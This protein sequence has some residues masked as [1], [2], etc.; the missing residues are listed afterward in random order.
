M[1]KREVQAHIATCMAE[2][3]DFQRA[4]VDHVCLRLY[5]EKCTRHLVADEVG[6]G[7]TIVAK[8][9]IAKAMERHLRST[10]AAEPFRVVYICSNQA[11]AGQNLIKLNL[12]KRK[13]CVDLN[14]SRLVFLAKKETSK[15]SFRII[16]LTPSTSF[17]LTK[18][19]GM[20]EERKLM[21]MLLSW[22]KV[23]HKGSRRNGLKLF[24]KGSVRDPAA[25]AAQLDVYE[26]E[27]HGRLRPD[28]YTRFKRSVMEEPVD[29]GTPRYRLVGEELGLQGVHSLQSIVLRYSERLRSNN[30]HKYAGP[31]RLIGLLRGLLT[32]ACLVYLKADLFILDEFQ[33]FKDLI[34]T[35]EE[36]ASDAALLAQQVFSIEKAK[37]LM[38][39][40][41]P[42]KP[43][44]TALEEQ[45][46]AESHH[47]EFEQVLGFLFKGDKEKVERYR[48][49]RKSFREL[50]KRAAE[51]DLDH[52]EAKDDLQDLLSEVMS[53]T[54]RL[55]VSDDHNTLIKS[56]DRSASTLLKN[57]I[58]DFIHTD[59]IAQVLKDVVKQPLM[60][61]VDFSRSC[62]FPFSF[63][64]QYQLK[65]LLHK[66]RGQEEVA[67]TIRENRK[68]WLDLKKVQQ[69]KPLEPIPNH[70]MRELISEA[71]GNGAFKQL[72]LPPTLPYY[73]ASKGAFQV[74][75]PPSKILLFSRWRMVPRAVA[76]LVS[77]E[78]ER[79]T[80]A[81]HRMSR[82][83]RQYTPPE[84]LGK[85]KREPKK[86]SPR[87]ALKLKEGIAASMTAFTLLYPSRTLADAIDLRAYIAPGH[88]KPLRQLRAQLITDLKA[89]FKE[90][91]LAEYAKGER[92]TPN[93]YWAAPLLMDK[94]FHKHVRD[95][96]FQKD[97]RESRFAQGRKHLEEEDEQA[98]PS[99][100]HKLHL[101]VLAE[102]YRG[103]R[104]DELGK[105]PEDLFHVL[106]DMALASP[107]CAA[108]R[109]LRNQYPDSSEAV[110]MNGALDIASEFLALFD[111]P[112]SIC[113]VDMNSMD[114]GRGR[115][116]STNVF[117]RSALEYCV[118]GNLQ[119]TLDEFAHLLRNDQRDVQGF[120]ERLSSSINIRTSSI[121][122]DDA[123]GFLN[124][125]HTLMRCHFAVEF[126]NQ[127]MEKDENRERMTNVLNNFNS[128]FWPFVLASTSVGQEG[129]D[130][131]LYCRKVMHWNLP[132]NPIDLEQREGRVNR[133][134]GLVVRQNVVKKYL[135]N[136]K[137]T[138]G[139]PW[140]ELFD[141]AKQLE[142][143]AR[144]KPE[145]VPYWHL[146]SDGI[147]IER[148][149]P[150]L[151][152]SRDVDHLER[153]LVVLTLY[154][155][156]F[157]QPRQEDLVNTLYKD[158][159]PEKLDEIRKKLMVDLS[160]I[161][162]KIRAGV[163]D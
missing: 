16:A 64:D 50:L 17:Q 33:R 46:H 145:L 15:E 83:Y 103:Q 105:V 24:F 136:L 62:P 102:M 132:S 148:L 38:L 93:W 162:R 29:L 146:E 118:D 87:L 130:F 97:H 63:L 79:R 70:R 25:W 142:G 67:T 139:D 124:D 121:R 28:V 31:N 104:L 100:T 47:E 13:E 151:P 14:T 27:W 143:T 7:K 152:Y 86:P 43:F 45:V 49:D 19:L 30:F 106:A 128:P 153:L 133:Y 34:D 66:H 72:W 90:A 101:Q 137:S 6:L 141:I 127:N 82:K 53:R 156:T 51:E 155:L 92:E 138:T 159:S 41:T 96:W 126:G 73:Y 68:G 35:S 131:H 140:A 110:A 32:K 94:A 80:I 60:G 23:Y 56:R 9:V 81:D 109:M 123:D 120:I 98:T 119:A 113:I 117:W 12:F 52:V 144:A 4:T 149:L 75:V 8:G 161:S 40:A 18:G 134:K 61:V 48:T 5:Q 11:L 54:E 135:A 74:E 107:A 10:R 65:A 115:A 99:R 36:E 69:Y 122:V 88:R 160:P 39:S 76:S 108:Y 114:Q 129:L 147:H 55:L 85:K 111:K 44:T 150:M 71:L 26:R 116:G 157:G 58:E 22:Y 57:D 59:R 163:E 3:K 78:V 37:V 20:A 1:D 154:R 125:E 84:L 21:W 77:Y 89:K 2:L 158:L 91:G 112:T 42:F 95:A